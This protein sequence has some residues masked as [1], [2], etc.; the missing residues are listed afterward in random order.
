MTM[1]ANIKRK[2]TKDMPAYVF[3]FLMY[4]LQGVPM[5]IGSA[6]P[7]VMQ[8]SISYSQQSLFSLITLPFSLKILWA[9]LVDT[10]R[11]PNLGLRKS[12][13]IPVQFL[14]SMMMIFGGLFETVERWVISPGLNLNL[15]KLSFYFFIL[16]FLMA[17]QDIAVDGW[18]LT[19]ISKENQGLAS[20]INTVGQ[21]FG[22]FFANYGFFSVQSDQPSQVSQISKFFVCCGLLSLFA[23][24]LVVLKT[25]T[26]DQK[27]PD[28]PAVDIQTVEISQVVLSHDTSVRKR[29]TNE[30]HTPISKI[31]ETPDLQPPENSD[32]TDIPH[33][34]NNSNSIHG[35]LES[36]FKLF[37]LT[38]LKSVQSLVV[39]LLLVRL[40][41][42]PV[43][44]ATSLKFIEFGVPTN[45]VAFLSQIHIPMTIFTAFLVGNLS[46]NKPMKFFFLWLCTANLCERNYRI[47][48]FLSKA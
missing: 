4:T 11:L 28:S 16:Y 20:P 45:T 40:G 32:L 23:S 27:T 43:E 6:L 41:F 17:T 19:L 36:Y 39:L 8:N 37:R 25:E 9:P 10:I 7:L 42:G 31:G 33:I 24:I 35:A 13:L 38:K 12:W 46:K 22:F 5:G 1:D 3:L 30:T 18:A 15:Y 2:W 34:P 44:S 26:S 48:L 21:A 29:I 47:I 14:C